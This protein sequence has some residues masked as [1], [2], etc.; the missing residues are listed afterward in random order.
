MLILRRP[1]QFL[2]TSVFLFTTNPY[3]AHSIQSEVTFEN[4]KVRLSSR[5]SNGEPVEGAVISILNQESL[6]VIELGQTNHLG[7]LILN[8][9]YLDSG[10]INVQIDG[11]PGHRD[12]LMIPIRSGKILFQKI[13]SL[14]YKKT[15][16]YNL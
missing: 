3:K 15:I 13:S 2:L 6:P 9:P 7:N 10:K 8:L 4:G 11:G 5:F 16:F 14:P 1:F 12:Y